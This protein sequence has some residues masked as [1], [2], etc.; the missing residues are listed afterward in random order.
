M[1]AAVG[2]HV[3]VASNVLDRPVREGTI[4]EVSRADGEPP[5]VVEWSD[6][7]KRSV[8]VPGADTRV[9]HEGEAPEKPAAAAAGQGEEKRPVKSW[10]I[11]IDVFESGD[12]TAAHA[13]LTSD[14]PTELDAEGHARRAHQDPVLPVVGDEVAVSRALR[15]LADRLLAAAS[16]DLETATGRRVSLRS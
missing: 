5:Y 4:V 14:S 10:R 13:V 1:R 8:F 9:R 6:T 16:I 15:Q 2:D 3:I 12:D 11:N 7:G